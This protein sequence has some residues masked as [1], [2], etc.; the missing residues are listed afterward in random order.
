MSNPLNVDELFGRI[1]PLDEL[2]LLGK[3]WKFYHPSAMGDL[4]GRVRTYQVQAVWNDAIDTDEWRKFQEEITLLSL[5][6]NEVLDK[7]RKAGERKEDES[8]R[9]YAVRSCMFDLTALQGK[10]EKAKRDQDNLRRELRINAIDKGIAY[11][12]TLALVEPEA[13]KSVDQASAL[14]ALDRIEE[15]LAEKS[16][17]SVEDW[18]FPEPEEE[19]EVEEE[20]SDRG[21]QVKKGKLESV[22]TTS[23]KP[24]DTPAA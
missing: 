14:Y 13:F 17:E 2:T 7:N 10:F 22:Q 5:E 16:G 11:L 9:D 23:K 1:K 8:I 19:L 20:D 3:S 12:E 21:K 18:L 4:K 15:K 6:Y 24:T